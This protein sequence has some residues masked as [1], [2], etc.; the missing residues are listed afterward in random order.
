M[1]KLNLG[2]GEDYRKGWI[3]VDS[4]RNV[5]TDRRFDLNKFPY[6]FKNHYFEKVL[7]QMVLEHLDNPIKVLKEVIRISQNKATIELIVPHA[8]SY[9]AITDIQHKTHFTENSFNKILLEE[10]ELDLV[11]KSVEFQFKNTWKE[12]IPFKKYLK[13][14]F[15]GIYDDIKFKFKVIK[16]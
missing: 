11:L 5:K 8:T 2:S 16:W 14:F 4:R 13:I 9:A 3:N 1:V 7:M 15:N 6:P 10:Y 12:Y